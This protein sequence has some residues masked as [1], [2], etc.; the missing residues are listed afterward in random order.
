MNSVKDEIMSAMASLPETA[1]YEDAMYR[2]YVI[3]KIHEGRDAVRNGQV[4]SVE[5]LRNEMLS[6]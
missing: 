4:I 6:W 1:T 2:L 3:E 5:Q